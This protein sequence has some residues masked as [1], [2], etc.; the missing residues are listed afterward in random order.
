MTYDQK[1]T[2]LSQ[3]GFIARDDRKLLVLRLEVDALLESPLS[4]PKHLSSSSLLMLL[5]VLVTCSLMSSA[6]SKCYSL[7]TTLIFGN[8]Q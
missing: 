1:E 8:K 5:R 3:Y 2:G 4:H 6:P 7:K